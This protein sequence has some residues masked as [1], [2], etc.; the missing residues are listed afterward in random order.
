[1]TKMPS[2]ITIGAIIRY[3]VRL[4]RRCGATTVRRR[5]AFPGG[6]DR[7]GTFC[8]TV[9]VM[10]TAIPFTSGPGDAGVAS[11]GGLHCWSSG[12]APYRQATAS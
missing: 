7:I 9:G 3:A 1:M 11:P 12:W 10:A 6:W 4:S 8:A 2:R 5:F